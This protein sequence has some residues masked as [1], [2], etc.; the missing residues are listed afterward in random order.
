MKKTWPVKKDEKKKK[1]K[2]NSPCDRERERIVFRKASLLQADNVSGKVKRESSS[3]Y[4]FAD[5]SG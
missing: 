5:V 1:K 2:E 3:Y 4:Y